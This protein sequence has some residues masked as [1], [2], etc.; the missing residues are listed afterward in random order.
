M[1]GKRIK[2]IAFT[3]SLLKTKQTSTEK[4]KPKQNKEILVGWIND[5]KKKVFL[6]CFNIKIKMER[7]L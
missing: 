5:K 7:I 1:W 4:N 6:K 3:Y 2:G